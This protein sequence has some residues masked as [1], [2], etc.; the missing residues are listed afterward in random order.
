MNENTI[1]FKTIQLINGLKYMSEKNVDDAKHIICSDLQIEKTE[2][3]FNIIE[4]AIKTYFK[5]I[6]SFL[7]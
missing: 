4:N 7:L 2:E 6:D 3:N 5:T 1:K